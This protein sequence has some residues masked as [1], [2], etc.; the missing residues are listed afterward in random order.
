VVAFLNHTR[1]GN[2]ARTIEVDLEFPRTRRRP[3]RVFLGRPFSGRFLS[4]GTDSDIDDVK[5]AI[6]AAS[7][8]GDRVLLNFDTR[9]TF[10]QARSFNEI[11]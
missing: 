3:I 6:K 11:V 10:G 9:P 1:M 4:G 7:A 2:R 5:R 8:K